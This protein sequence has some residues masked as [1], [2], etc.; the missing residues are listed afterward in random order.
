[1]ITLRI[2]AKSR[3]NN[4][5]REIR[6]IRFPTSH[7]PKKSGI[8][9]V[10]VRKMRPVPRP[11]RQGPMIRRRKFPWRPV[12]AF[13]CLA[14][15]TTVITGFAWYRHKAVQAS[16]LQK[17]LVQANLPAPITTLPSSFG[18]WISLIKETISSF[19]GFDRSSFEAFG[20]LA[21]AST[22]IESIPAR[23]L[24]SDG[25]GVIADLTALSEDIKSLRNSLDSVSGLSGF[26]E[27]VAY[28][29]DLDRAQIVI[30]RLLVMLQS[31]GEHH[32]LILF[33]NSAEL[34]PGGGFL[35]SF[36]DLLFGSS[37]IGKIT[38]HDINEVDR[39]FAANVVPPKPAQ[40]IVTR[41]RAADANWFFDY[42]ESA[43]KTLEFMGRSSSYA[44]STLVG[45]ILISP[46]VIQDLLMATGPVSLDDGKTTVTADTIISLIQREVQEGQASGAANP[47]EIL[48]KLLPPLEM[49]L[50][51]LEPEAT[52]KLI[53]SAREWIRNRDVAIYMED[54]ELAKVV[55]YYRADA[56]SYA[57][58]QN[59]S[60]DYFAAVNANLGGGKSD[61]RISDTIDF[62]S[63]LRSDGV[64][65]NRV[66]VVRESSATASDEWW[67]RVT[68]QNYLQVFTPPG[69]ILTATGGG[70]S[71]SIAPRANYSK[72]FEVDP[73]LVALEAT[74]KPI[75]GFAS[76]SQSRQSNKNVFS[77]WL[78]TPAGGS[79]IARFEYRRDLR[80][81]FRDGGNYTFVF[82]RQSGAHQSLHAILNAPPGF[83]WEESGFSKYEYFNE[84]V[85]GRVVINLTLVEL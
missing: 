54:P 38:V 46:K 17:V 13:A 11:P 49:K 60:G 39:G 50:Q 42:P 29:P 64:I 59:F 68:N 48:S 26:S 77:T 51:N 27:Y 70:K 14:I 18:G 41:W 37:T 16:H 74:L 72:D 62:E 7:A 85:P 40:G 55:S 81:P 5:P 57:I 4:T 31:P 61:A 80:T 23:V 8:A 22:L 78:T 56:S 44:S 10:P 28:I 15:L 2:M 71:R 21:R 75:P 66:A 58:P 12:A 30:D 34:R 24:A 84:I 79:G 35:G 36:A 73:D 19:G 52:E 25:P 53:A 6:D 3:D 43:R 69:A 67:Y 47:K 76:V 82:E 63:Y 33:G 1:M 65:E 83:V 9:E 32:L 20:A 45:A